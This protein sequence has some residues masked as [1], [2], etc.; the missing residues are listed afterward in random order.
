MIT[1]EFDHTFVLNVYTPNSGMKLDRLPYR[2]EY[3]AAFSAYVAELQAKKPV[4]I[5]GDLN[6]TATSRDLANN[7]SR[8]NKV[9]GIVVYKFFFAM[10]RNTIY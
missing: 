2:A 8:Y 10:E 9:P 7:K 6:V 1:L 3:D 5:M 4:L